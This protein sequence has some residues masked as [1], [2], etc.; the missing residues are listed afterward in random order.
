MAEP[1]KPGRRKKLPRGNEPIETSNN[2]LLSTPFPPSLTPC[3]SGIDKDKD[4]KMEKMEEITELFLKKGR[5][6]KE[7]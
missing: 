2:K 3:P 7:P 6:R 4:I 1:I 5:K